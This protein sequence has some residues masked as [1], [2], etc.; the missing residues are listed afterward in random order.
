MGVVT[1]VRKVNQLQA[2]YGVPLPLF[3]PNQSLEDSVCPEFEIIWFNVLCFGHDI[4]DTITQ[5]KTDHVSG[6]DF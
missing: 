4:L 6:P 5:K 1:L 2:K 3:R